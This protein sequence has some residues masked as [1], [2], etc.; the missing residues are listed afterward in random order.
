ML[1]DFAIDFRPRQLQDSYRFDFAPLAED[2][3]RVLR[4]DNLSILLIRRSPATLLRLR[5]ASSG[6]QD[7]D[8]RRSRQPAFAQN[9]LRSRHPEFFVAYAIGTDFGCGLEVGG[10]ELKEVCGDARYDFAGR[11][12][13]GEREFKN[14]PVPDYNFSGD[15]TSL[16]VRP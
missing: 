10:F 5:E 2:E 12:F 16:T 3:V 7:P 15:Y 4:H 1:V 9:P 14:L 6:L 8:S 11:A 13:E